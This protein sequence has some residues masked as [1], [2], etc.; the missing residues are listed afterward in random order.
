MSFK[1]IIA[2]GY[3]AASV[4][5]SFSEPPMTGSFKSPAKFDTEQACVEAALVKSKQFKDDAE[6]VKDEARKARNVPLDA[7]L[8]KYGKGKDMDV[9]KQ[10]DWNEITAERKKIF[11]ATPPIPLSVAFCI[12]TD[13][14]EN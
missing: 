10:K 9:L 14:L 4:L 8:A 2:T 11:D 5:T 12:D 3:F 7:A 13:L 6:K 1:L